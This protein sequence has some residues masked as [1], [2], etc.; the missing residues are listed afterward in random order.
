MHQKIEIDC[1][2]VQD[3]LTHILFREVDTDT[4]K[5][6]MKHLD[7]CSECREEESE[8]LRTFFFMRR[9]REKTPS[10]ELY[11][12][13]RGNIAGRR[14][15]RPAP[16]LLA[17]LKEFF[18]KPVPAYSLLLFGLLFVSLFSF[19]DRI[20]PPGDIL[21][22]KVQLL[23][24]GSGPFADTLL[25]SAHSMDTLISRGEI[26]DTTFMS[27]MSALSVEEC[28]IQK[29]LSNGIELFITARQAGKGKRTLW[30]YF[31]PKASNARETQP[32]SYWNSS[33]SDSG[34]SSFTV[35]RRSARWNDSPA[36]RSAIAIREL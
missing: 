30:E 6:A 21:R 28:I 34:Y 36:D 10:E 4:F 24:M 35:S 32:I 22:G 29:N 33:F 11:Q 26:L 5:K 2:F 27:L 19:Q 25:F 3:N 12:R 20:A 13:L 31:V 15:H 18:R 7:E 17:G 23:V 16:S 14:N 1:M 9:M 8:Y